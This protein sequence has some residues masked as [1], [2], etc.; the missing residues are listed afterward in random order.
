[1]RRDVVL[2]RGD[3]VA[4]YGN[5]IHL[6]LNRSDVCGVCNDLVRICVSGCTF[7]VIAID[8]CRQPAR[9]MDCTN[10]VM[11]DEMARRIDEMARNIVYIAYITPQIILLATMLLGKRTS[12]TVPFNVRRLKYPG[13]L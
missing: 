8:L 10:I 11:P 1:M 3:L 5:G 6:V 4:V 7:V 13:R 2:V 9:V 12:G